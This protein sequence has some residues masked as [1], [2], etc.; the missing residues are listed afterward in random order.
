[1]DNCIDKD[2][3][4]KGVKDNYNPEENTSMKISLF[5]K[6]DMLCTFSP[7]TGVLTVISSN[8]NVKFVLEPHKIQ[9]KTATFYIEGGKVGN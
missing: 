9:G 3:D 5:N 2:Q 6:T 8:K 7:I 1:M 4:S